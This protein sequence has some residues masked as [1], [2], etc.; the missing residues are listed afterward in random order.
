M[1][2]W[3]LAAALLG[4]VAR[5]VPEGPGYSVLLVLHVGAAFVSFGTL[6]LTGLQAFR[7]RRGPDQPGALSLRRYFRPGV[8]WV[9]R[10]LYAVPVLG[11]ALVADSDGAFAA[12]DG[13]V[14]AGLL[15]WLAAAVVAE[16][17]VWPGERRI[18]LLVSEQWDDPSSV[19]TLRLECRRVAAASA[20]LAGVFVAAVVIMVGKP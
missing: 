5:P 18:Q 2:S 13:W 8:N 9:G 15:L 16:A 4:V 6:G 12:A 14:V 3:C 1:N 10:L 7:A 11:F 17:V 19:G 20:A